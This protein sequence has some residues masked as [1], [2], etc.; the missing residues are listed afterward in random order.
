MSNVNDRYI[1]EQIGLHCTSG[2]VRSIRVVRDET[3]HNKFPKHKRHCLPPVVRG[4]TPKLTRKPSMRQQPQFDAF[5]L[6]HSF[7]SVGSFGGASPG[8]HSGFSSGTYGGRKV[9]LS[10][11]PAK[12]QPKVVMLKDYDQAGFPNWRL[13]E[14][15][16]LDAS[17][18]IKFDVKCTFGVP[19]SSL[20]RVG[21]AVTTCV[22]AKCIK[23]GADVSYE[24]SNAGS[25]A[26]LQQSKRLVP[27]SY[28]TPPLVFL[29]DDSKDYHAESVRRSKHHLC[30]LNCKTCS[31]VSADLAIFEKMLEIRA[32]AAHEAQLQMEANRPLHQLHV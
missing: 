2:F 22:C 9:S 26:A 14:L 10:P 7:S 27:H 20:R 18:K 6:Q 8:L 1:S 19:V 24:P 23:R 17:P 25:S 32:Q 3:A 13:H 11:V 28:T 29:D 5:T 4:T 30:G 12:P 16:E 15:E 21:G 31:N